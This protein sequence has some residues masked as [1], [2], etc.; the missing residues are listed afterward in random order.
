[1]A[2]QSLSSD[3]LLLT[4]ELNS[5]R[6]ERGWLAGC[7]RILCVGIGAQRPQDRR[8]HLTPYP[9][10]LRVGPPVINTA[11]IFYFGSFI[12][13]FLG[14]IWRCSG[15]TR[16]SSL[17]NYSRQAQGPDRMGCWGSNLVHDLHARPTP[18]FRCAI[19]MASLLWVLFQ[20][21]SLVSSS[22]G[23]G[24]S[25]G[26]SSYL[27]GCPPP[28]SSGEETGACLL[29]KGELPCPR[30]QL[31]LF[32][33]CGWLRAWTPAASL[34]PGTSM[35]A[36]QFSPVGSGGAAP[37]AGSTR[38]TGHQ[39]SPASRG[40]PRSHREDG[41]EPLVAGRSPVGAEI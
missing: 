39:L 33:G 36:A 15:V 20:C 4:T 25:P 29:W 14:H 13:F 8:C 34:L 23:S 2:S 17:W 38:P 3:A 22:K 10:V 21:P 7:M 24:R 31:R 16:G 9:V 5:A 28:G 40:G 30:T 19:T 32:L 1:M 26:V 11:A 35:P 27:S 18:P 37:W 41:A 12:L 6:W